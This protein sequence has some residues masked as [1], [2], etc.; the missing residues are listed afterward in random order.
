MGKK[1]KESVAAEVSSEEIE[2]DRVS[3]DSDEQ[4]AAVDAEQNLEEVEKKFGQKAINDEEG[5]KVR[6]SE[7]QKNFYNRLE[8]A[9][10]VKK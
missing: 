5:L 1:V 10:L 9:K 2:D 7:I 3:L 8:S 4:I 6:L